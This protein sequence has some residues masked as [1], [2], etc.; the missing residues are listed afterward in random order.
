MGNRRTFS[1]EFKVGSASLVLEQDYMPLW[2]LAGQ[3]IS[4]QQLCVVELIDSNKN[5]VA[6][7]QSPCTWTATYPGIRNQ[8]QTDRTREKNPEK[9]DGFVDVGHNL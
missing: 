3:L 2:K 1:A 8:D 7:C 4:M 9:S 6:L 5:E